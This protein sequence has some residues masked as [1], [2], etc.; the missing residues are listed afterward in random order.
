LFVGNTIIFQL[1]ACALFV[2][3]QR[4]VG[5]M[6]RRDAEAREEQRKR[7]HIKEMAIQTVIVQLYRCPDWFD[8]AI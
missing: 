3:T 2:Q 5:L 8:V 7:D 6:D 4:K 1:F